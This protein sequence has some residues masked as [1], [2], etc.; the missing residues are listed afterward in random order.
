[1]QRLVQC[2]IRINIA[3]FARSVNNERFNLSLIFVVGSAMIL[4]ILFYG[5]PSGYDMPHH[6]QLALTFRDSIL[7]GDLYPSWT[8]LRN[9][10]YGSLELRLYPPVSH[11]VLA[12]SSIAV[13]DWHLA[14]W[15]TYTFW[16]VLGSLGVYLWAREIVAPRYAVIAALIYAVMPYRLNQAYLVFFYGELAGSSILPFCFAFFTRCMR[17]QVDLDRNQRSFLGTI[18]TINTVGFACSYAFL[19]LTH[20]PLTLIVSF[21][22]GIYGI[23]NLKLDWGYSL[24]LCLRIG[25]SGLIALL[26]TSFFWLKVVQERFL[27]AKTSVYEDIYLHYSLN[28]LI[29]PLQ[30]YDHDSVLAFEAFT[31]IYDIT[32]A[33]TMFSII[34]IALMAF[35]FD[36]WR[37][38]QTLSAGSITFT[39]SAFLTT[40]LS[41]VVWDNFSLMQEVQ[42]PW[43]W[44]AIVSAFAPVLAAAGLPAVHRW[45]ISDRRPYAFILIG[46][47]MIGSAFAISNSIRGAIYKA[48][49]QIDDYVSQIN[50]TEGFQFWWPIWARKEVF[51][52]KERVLFANR[53]SSVHAWGSTEK[54]FN[55]GAGRAGDA[56]I[57]VFYHPNW[58]AKVNGTPVVARPDPNGAL[59]IPLAEAESRVEVAFVENQWVQIAGYISA[60]CWILVFG[61]VIVWLIRKSKVP[62]KSGKADD[63][64]DQPAVEVG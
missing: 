54:L 22:L 10:G 48:P 11:Y 30:V 1:M 36:N 58:Q 53:E 57:A 13:G 59:L 26:A 49:A 15:L 35:R 39:V 20:L 41:K 18:F 27:V 7:A 19:I 5:V 38:R 8:N 6:Y 21:A 61:W 9:L 14:T 32:L 40:I 46:F 44:L 4:P 34:P 28:F 12:L 55:V 60:F 47:L 16:W 52:I 64:Y 45:L 17:E 63:C 42:F 31:L 29:T 2:L 50:A 51:E 24:R 62:S 43:R 37:S 56:R 33:V 25:L 23:A 3:A